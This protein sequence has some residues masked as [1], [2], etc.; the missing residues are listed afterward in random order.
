MAFRELDYQTRALGALDA[1]LDALSAE[2]VKA[3]KAAAFIAENPDVGLE[4]P[5]FP[6]KA[7]ETLK[8]AGQLV[9]LRQ[10]RRG[11][12]RPGRRGNA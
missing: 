9:G 3:D 5:N 11:S 10:R 6:A 8:L 1:Y 7:W 2:K 12:R 4:L